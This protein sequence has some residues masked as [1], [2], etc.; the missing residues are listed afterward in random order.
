M[1]YNKNQLKSS[2][3]DADFVSF[4]KHTLL[5]KNGEITEP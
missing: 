3:S 4:W 2:Y 5:S 1:K